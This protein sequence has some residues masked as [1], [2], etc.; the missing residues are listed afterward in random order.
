MKKDFNKRY[1]RIFSRHPSHRQI[2]KGNPLAILYKHIACIR[3]GS[4]TKLATSWNR[5]PLQ[6]NSVES[7]KISSSKLLM[8]KAFKDAKIITAEY[9][10]DYSK[11]PDDA[12]P[13]LAKLVYGSRGRGLF[14]CDT[15]EDL[16]SLI[17]RNKR[18]TSNDYYFEKFY[19]YTREYRLHATPVIDKCFYT[20]RK[21]LLNDTPED[22]KFFRNDSNC[23]W[24]VEENSKFDKPKNWNN[25]KK[26]AIKA[27]AATGLDIGA[28][29]VRVRGKLDKSGNNPFIIIE[30]NSAP[31]FGDRTAVEYSKVIPEILDAKAK[32]LNY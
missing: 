26:E 8:K 4:T 11:I 31:S 7:I 21:M 20:N 10:K 9:W 27:I 23:V 25:I 1:L 15:R 24:Y 2:R 6:I 30:V 14:K 16:E 29:D 3:F 13:I 12:F 17:S 32:L 28:V 19:N 18:I 22:K 5:S